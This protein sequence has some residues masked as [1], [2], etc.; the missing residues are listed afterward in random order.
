[1]P[2][3]KLFAF[4]FFL[5]VGFHFFSSLLVGF[6]ECWSGPTSTDQRSDNPDRGYFPHFLMTNN[7]FV[8]SEQKNIGSPL[9]CTIFSPE[10]SDKSIATCMRA[11]EIHTTWMINNI[12][13]ICILDCFAD[14]TYVRSYNVLDLAC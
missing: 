2:V 9:L 13:Y 7:L 4:L 11:D 12:V 1:M 10:F 6:R 8:S 3:G 5:P 14:F